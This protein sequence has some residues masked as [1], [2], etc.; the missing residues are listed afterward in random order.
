MLGKLSGRTH[1]VITAFCVRN[2]DNFHVEADEAKVTFKALT[3]A[4]IAHYVEN[5]HPLDKAGAYGAQDWIGMVGVHKIEGSF[6]TVMGL[7]THKL[8]SHLVNLG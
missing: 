4:E 6:F 8:Y 5:Y 2:G 7:P 1:Q 3:A